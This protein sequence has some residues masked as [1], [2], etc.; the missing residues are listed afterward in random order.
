MMIR[1]LAIGL[2][3]G[4]VMGTA[5]L[6]GPNFV[7]HRGASA[8]AP[9]NTL[10]AFRRAINVEGA[11]AIEADFHLTKDGQVICIH[12]KTTQRTTGVKGVVAEMTFDQLR[13]LEA[14]R[15]KAAAYAGE[16]LPTMPEV[17]ALVSPGKRIFIEIKVGPAIIPPI[18]RH[19]EASGLK[20]EQVVFISFNEQSLAAIKQA[21]PQCKAQLLYGFKKDKQGRWNATGDQVIEKAKKLGADGVD[22]SLN[23]ETLEIVNPDFA[24]KVRAAGLELHVWTVNTPEMGRKALEMN[25]DSITTDRPQGLRQQLAAR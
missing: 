1:H 13:A 25:V 3:L 8:E 6:A 2:L 23:P 9:E 4:L 16:K 21:M 20:S 14:G 22:V 11:D 15:W 17:L 24:R 12:D 10:A 18:Q 7:A 5:A 19:V